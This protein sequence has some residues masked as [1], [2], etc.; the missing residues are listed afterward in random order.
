M[1]ITDVR[2]NIDAIRQL[3]LLLDQPEPQVEIEAR[4]VVATRSFSRDLGVQLSASLTGGRGAG[5]TVVTDPLLGNSPNT[6]ITLTT[7]L[8]GTA[9]ISAFINLGEQKG[10]A[11][12]IATPRVTTLNNR[13]AEIKSGLQIPITT[14]QPGSGGTEDSLVLT[15]EYIEVPLRLAVTPQITDVGTI[16]LNVVAENSNVAPAGGAGNAPAISTQS[17]QTQVMV[18]DGGTTVVG[19]VLLDAEEEQ[20]N[21]TPGL[22][23][24]PLLGYLFKRKSV[25]RSTNELLFFITPRIYRPD[26]NG[27]PINGKISD[28]TRTTTIIQPVPLGNPPSNSTP[29]VPVQVVP[30]QQYPVNPNVQPTNPGTVNRP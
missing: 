29:V 24:I 28:G 7:G 19:G 23:R 1:I 14:V 21:R 5:G 30:N 8:I 26:Y 11:K 2:E 25:T 12:T 9:R 15:T 20:Q 18:P 3:V 10:Q 22:S 27:K 13:P 6:F 17:M 4:V 16:L